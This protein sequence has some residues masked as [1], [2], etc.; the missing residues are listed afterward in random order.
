MR[1][2]T[3]IFLLVFGLGLLPL[4]VLVTL[5]LPTTISR[6]DRAAELESQARSQVQFAR[7]NARINCL[8]KSLI[9]AATLPAVTMELASGI[10][11]DTVPSVLTRWFDDDR[12]VTDLCL[13]DLQGTLHLSLSRKENS[14]RS[15]PDLHRHHPREQVLSGIEGLRENE[16]MARLVHPFTD[17]PSSADSSKYDLLMAT[18]VYNHP[19]NKM[20][21]AMVMRIDLSRFLGGYLDS[22]WLSGSGEFLRGCTANGQND[23]ITC[24]SFAASP[25][26]RGPVDPGRPVRIR[27]AA[28]RRVAWL[29]IVFNPRQKALMWIGSVI[30]ESSTLQWKRFLLGNVVAVI[31]VMVLLVFGLASWMAARIDSLRKDLLHGLNAIVDREK[32]V[33]FSWKGPRE[34]RELAADLTDF[35]SCYATNCEAR[36]RARDALKESEDK[37]RNL[38]ESALDGIIL[39]DNTG[40]ITYWNEAATTI[41][42]YSGDQALNQPIHTLIDPRRTGEEPGLVAPPAEDSD[43]DLR[44]TLEL[45]ARRRD[46]QSIP[47]E[48]SLSSARINNQWHAIWIVRDI[49]ERKK[50]EERARQ[51]QAQLLQADKMISLGLLVS[52]VAHEINNPNSIAL[53]NLP[54]LSRAW[55]DCLPILDEFFEENGDFSV[56]GLSYTEMRHQVI[57]LCAELEESALRIR[58]IVKDLKD[59]VRQEAAG[60]MEEVAVDEVVQAA[61]RLTANQVRKSRARLVI[62]GRP[63]LMVPGHRQRLI[64]VLINLIQNSCE[65]LD[66][67]QANTITVTTRSGSGNSEVEIEIRDTGSGIAPDI[68]DK[69]T[70]PFFTTRKNTGG[71]GLGL[72]VSS[73]IIKEH[74]GRIH[75]SSQPGQGTTVTVILPAVGE[76]SRNPAPSSQEAAP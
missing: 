7:L 30:D 15:N 62:D 23:R 74:R 21:G 32:T 67:D 10:D 76:R 16:V 11:S 60:P 49:S 9:R 53:L 68:L 65:A 6:L 71:T 59:Y 73:G 44:R 28:G 75:F 50:S 58:Q 41:F 19:R 5:I 69:V 64:Q 26:L 42:G 40:R 63:G 31:S 36:N 55:Q 46:G 3:V 22:H 47:V 12:Q 29:P 1:I 66:P 24:E 35:S 56:A 34:I 13:F 18:P 17:T 25:A 2:R 38:T 27:D 43:P 37:F 45:T 54:R 8:K 33:H 61:V 39:M 48:V 20:T 4:L 57:R 72:S 52:G 51:Q 14:L 70:D